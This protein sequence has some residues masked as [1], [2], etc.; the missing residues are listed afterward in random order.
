M[1]NLGC[2]RNVC[3]YNSSSKCTNIAVSMASNCGLFLD[4][5]SKKEWRPTSLVR[6]D[7]NEQTC[8]KDSAKKA[9]GTKI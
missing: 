7:M 4:V 6:P 9:A 8:A 3:F 1:G 2:E 5:N